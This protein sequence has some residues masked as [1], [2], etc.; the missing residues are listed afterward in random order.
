MV[1]ILNMAEQILTDKTEWKRIQK[2]MAEKL[3][4]A[5]GDKINRNIKD[6]VFCDLFGRQ[7]YLFQLY[8]ALH[9]ED[10]ETTIDV[11][12]LVTIVGQQYEG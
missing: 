5:S 6:S 2:L 4:E 7:E 8:Q 9:P 3:P 11:L 1:I 12:T 10:T